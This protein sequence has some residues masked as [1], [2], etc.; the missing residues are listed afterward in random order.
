MST[1]TTPELP[2]T[3]TMKMA[4]LKELNVVP[5]EHRSAALKLAAEV[6]AENTNQP[7]PEDDEHS[8]F[9]TLGRPIGRPFT[10]G[11]S[12]PPEVLRV[13]REV[14]VIFVPHDAAKAPRDAPL[15]SI[16][17]KDDREKNIVLPGGRKVPKLVLQPYALFYPHMWLEKGYE[18]WIRG[19]MHMIAGTNVPDIHVLKLRRCEAMAQA[20]FKVF[21]KAPLTEEAVTFWFGWVDILVEVYLLMKY[22][23]HKPSSATLTFAALLEGRIHS[24]KPLDYYADI[25][26][27]RNAVE[28]PKNGGFRL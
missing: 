12:L 14:C 4:I 3:S 18:E 19:W 8:L 2:Y 22:T 16:E 1:A 20:W 5:E 24:G 13:L 15:L 26:A 10:L 21:A 25:L 11:S 9:S 27:S 7:L 17:E 23:G 28:V 6:M